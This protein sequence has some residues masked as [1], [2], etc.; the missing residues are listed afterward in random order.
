MLDI[1]NAVIAP[2]IAA[3]ALGF[4]NYSILS[5]LDT[6]NLTKEMNEDKKAYLASF[7]AG[8]YF[9]F[10]F[11]QF[12][13]SKFIKMKDVNS[14]LSFIL[15]FIC[16]T[17]FTYYFGDKI[18]NWVK[19]AINTKR[20]NDG[21]SLY[22]SRSVKNIALNLEKSCPMYVYDF[23]NRLIWAGYSGWFSTAEGLDLEFTSV[24]FNE[25]PELFEYYDLLEYIE[26]I[27]VEST[28]YINTDKKIKIILLIPIS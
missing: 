21:K 22:D 19:N 18:G 8:N 12:L 5:R 25:K 3:G 2:L 28:A 17:L 4:I 15:T 14:V 7:G 9:L 11:V 13:L 24:P 23:E 20:S 10:T 6:I 16:T 1:Q 27:D 26:S